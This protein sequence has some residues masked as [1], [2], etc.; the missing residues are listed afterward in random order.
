MIVNMKHLVSIL[1]KQ[2]QPNQLAV[3]LLRYKLCF[4]F[5]RYNLA[6]LGLGQIS[7][8]SKPSIYRPT[9]ALAT[10]GLQELNCFHCHFSDLRK[11]DNVSSNSFGLSSI[12]GHQHNPSR[13]LL[14]RW[15]LWWMLFGRW[16][17]STTLYSV[18]VSIAFLILPEPEYTFCLYCDLSL[19][20]NIVEDAQTINFKNALEKCQIVA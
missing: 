17:V 5:Y 8:N 19:P 11:I 2:T 7:N 10:V 13:G 12:S 15:K 14:L 9:V 16:L 3:N 1:F 4:I 20:I 6:Y 18:A